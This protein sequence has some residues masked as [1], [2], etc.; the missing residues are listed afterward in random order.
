MA[1]DERDLRHLIEK[2][3]STFQ[4]ASDAHMADMK[5]TFRLAQADPV[6]ASSEEVKILIPTLQPPNT[7]LFD[8]QRFQSLLQT[9]TLAHTFLYG[10]VVESTQSIL[11][12]SVALHTSTC[13]AILRSCNL[14]QEPSLPQ[15][16]ARWLFSYCFFPD[17][18]PRSWKQRLAISCRQSS[19]LFCCSIPCSTGEQD[20][21]HPVS[22]RSGCS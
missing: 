5:D 17:R 21:L 7:P 12:K 2:L 14:S 20:C 19:F 11:D 13:N 3:S 15:R 4:V 10:Q 1:S 22:F 8:T 18:R 9:T 6:P 16:S